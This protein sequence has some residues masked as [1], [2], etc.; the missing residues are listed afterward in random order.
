MT[1]LLYLALMLVTAL[2]CTALVYAAWALPDEDG[3][4]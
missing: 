2:L 1:A 3:D 4:E